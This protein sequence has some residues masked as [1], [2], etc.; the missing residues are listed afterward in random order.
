MKKLVLISALV[1][2]AGFANAEELKDSRKTIAENLNEAVLVLKNFFKPV[3]QDLKTAKTE[4]D[5]L[6]EQARDLKEKSE[7][8]ESNPTALEHARGGVILD[9]DARNQ[10]LNWTGSKWECQDIT[11]GTDCKESSAEDRIK[12]ADG[13][14]TCKTPGSY[15]KNLT[16]WGPCNGTEKQTQVACMFTQTKGSKNSFQVSSNLSQCKAIKDP[17]PRYRQPCGSNGRNS[18]CKCPSGGTYIYSGGRSYCQRTI[19]QTIMG[20][21]TYNVNF[22]TDHFSKL[23]IIPDGSYIEIL[24]E[25]QNPGGHTDTRCNFRDYSAGWL[26]SK[27]LKGWGRGAYK[28]VA[29]VYVGAGYTNINNFRYTFSSSGSGCHTTSGS[30]YGSSTS[31]SSS[32]GYGYDNR[33]LTYCPANSAQHPKIRISFQSIVGKKVVTSGVPTC[34]M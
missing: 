16:G 12:N 9:C 14:Y 21:R 25:G 1:I 17:D 34:R 23:R 26:N 7:K 8:L 5:G 20:A 10:E 30:G 24:L 3:E 11:Y 27:G 19:N 2:A 13:S 18:A 15:S 31:G 29:R 6:K 33:S 4:T 22:C 28:R 32:Y